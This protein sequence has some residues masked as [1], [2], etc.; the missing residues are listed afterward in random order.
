MPIFQE[1]TSPRKKFKLMFGFGWAF[2]PTFSPELWRKAQ[3]KIYNGEM[4]VS[5]TFFPMSR[6]GKAPDMGPGTEEMA[7]K[8]PKVIYKPCSI[9]DYEASSCKR[10]CQSLSF[11][12]DSKPL[13]I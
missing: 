10:R 12:Y 8:M 1:K 6:D 2:F 9:P 3:Q 7:G 4:P 5:G 13:M 11:N